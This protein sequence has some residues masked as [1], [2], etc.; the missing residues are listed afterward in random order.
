VITVFIRYTLEPGRLDDFRLYAQRWLEIIPC[1][2][3]DL[4]G[5]LMPHEGTNYAAYGLV[6]FSC[7]AEYELYRLRLKA[8]DGRRANFDFAKERGFILR[9]DRSFLIQV[10]QL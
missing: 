4:L 3:G 2:G 10:Q 8:S 5:Y 6:S 7:L 9:E 1:S